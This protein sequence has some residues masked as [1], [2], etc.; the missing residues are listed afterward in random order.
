MEVSWLV[1]WSPINVASLI[2]LSL[3]ESRWPD[4]I[5][6][7][8]LCHRTNGDKFIYWLFFFYHGDEEGIDDTSAGSGQVSFCTWLGI[9]FL[10]ETGR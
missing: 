6:S 8:F 3:F 5:S 7:Y 9:F 2:L 4:F 10:A 1:L